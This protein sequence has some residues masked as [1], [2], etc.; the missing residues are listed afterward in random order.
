MR[1]DER[2]VLQD[3]WTAL[4]RS[5]RNNNLEMLCH[6][7]ANGADVTG[8]RPHLS[9]GKTI[10]AFITLCLANPVKAAAVRWRDDLKGFL[11]SECKELMPVQVTCSW[12]WMHL[13]TVHWSLFYV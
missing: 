8:L 9:G 6:L 1:S 12:T 3:G 5:A 7:V 2:D 13:Q 4:I 11:A 10:S